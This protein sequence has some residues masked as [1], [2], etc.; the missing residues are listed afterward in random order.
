MNKQENQITEAPAIAGKL[1]PEG[2]VPESNTISVPTN[3]VLH[4]DIS[5]LLPPGMASSEALT[6]YN[7]GPVDIEDTLNEMRALFDRHCIMTESEAD[8]IVLWILSSY[9]INSFRIFPMLTLVSPEK[10]CGKSTALELI[11]S[12]SKDSFN[13]TNA[14]Q[15][16]MYRIA[17]SQQPTLLL[18]E[19]DTFIKTA[20]GEIV[21]LLNGSFN[22]SSA[23]VSRCEG[24]S[25]DAKVHSTWYPKV[26]AS[27]G[28]L[29]ST[30]MDRSI[31]INLRR[32]KSNEF[33]QKLPADP[34]GQ[35][36]LIRQK[37]AR[38]CI[39]NLENIKSNTIEPKNIGNDRA[40]DVWLPLFTV[41]HQVSTSWKAKCESAYETL[42]AVDEPE[43][44][45]QL[46]IDVREILATHTEEKISTQDLLDKLCEDI[47]KPW[48]TINRGRKLTGSAM[49]N[50]LKPYGIKPSAYRPSGGKTIRGYRKQAFVDT[51]E[52]Y[53]PP[54]H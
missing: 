6:P 13:L 5:P 36:K 51:F 1:I 22:R 25:F 31:V 16:I 42:T 37:L 34:K 50:F 39:D 41:A 18:D 35:H 10:R 17:T 26:L 52:R 46:L 14:T 4:T 43:I 48:Q 44:P 19:A 9:L 15:A 30:I 38:W 29:Q 21:G 2:P 53:L 28:N 7:E 32:K 3:T 12:L 24:E 11:Y 33:I 54:L 49:A 20:S 40:V 45:T 8:A 47:N 23:N 27:I